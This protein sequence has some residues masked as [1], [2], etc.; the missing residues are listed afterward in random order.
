MSD[1]EETV[2]EFIEEEEPPAKSTG[3]GEKEKAQRTSKRR[4]RRTAEELA[5]L[6][7][8]EL[9]QLETLRTNARVARLRQRIEYDVHRYVNT[10]KTHAIVILQ[11]KKGPLKVV[12]SAAMVQMFETNKSFQDM[13]KLALSQRVEMVETNEPTPLPKRRRH[14]ADPE[15]L[16]ALNARRKKRK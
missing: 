6:T 15:M 2:P 3:V 5:L 16:N 11:P 8:D 9:A 14:V 1:D 12:G 13:F 10:C 7:P 4:G